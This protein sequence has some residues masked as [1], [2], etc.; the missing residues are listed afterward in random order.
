MAIDCGVAVEVERQLLVRNWLNVVV[1]VEIV[2]TVYEVGA[3]IIQYLSHSAISAEVLL[4]RIQ[5]TS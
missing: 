1:V 5:D 3:L 2:V 4:K